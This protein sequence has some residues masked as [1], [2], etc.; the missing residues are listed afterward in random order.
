MSDPMKRG[1]GKTVLVVD[2]NPSIRKMIASA[3]RSEGYETRADVENGLEGIAAAKKIKPDLITLD[4][5]MPVMNGLQASSELR[6]IFP[7][8]PIILFTLYGDSVPVTEASRAGVNLVLT[9]T[10]PL[11][12]LLDK[13]DEL[14]GG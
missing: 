5:S 1:A 14:I 2:D 7:A 8:V 13:A 3:F 9:K 11:D 10:T 12:T 4:L 6:K